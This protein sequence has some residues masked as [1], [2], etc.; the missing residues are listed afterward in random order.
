MGARILV[1]VARRGHPERGGRGRPLPHPRSHKRPR[2]D[3]RL[4]LRSV[5]F[6]H[7]TGST[8]VRRRGAAPPTRRPSPCPRSRPGPRECGLLATPAHGSRSLP[9]FSRSGSLGIPL[10][11][12]S[13]AAPSPLRCGICVTPLEASMV[14]GCI[15]A[16]LL[17]VGPSGR[18]QPNSSR[19]GSPGRGEAVAKQGAIGADPPAT[20]SATLAPDHDPDLAAGTPTSRGATDCSESSAEVRFAALG[21][22]ENRT[23]CTIR[24]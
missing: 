19:P 1:Q 22:H 2:P 6:P 11:P 7:K 20:S 12:R 16:E 13:R 15:A 9:S 4:A 17:S 10:G 3:R 14:H 23:P 24:L 18:S 21:T 8:P 5:R